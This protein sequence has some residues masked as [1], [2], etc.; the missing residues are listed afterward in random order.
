MNK[1]ES[2]HMGKDTKPHPLCRMRAESVEIPMLA[3][4]PQLMV[5]RELNNDDAHVGD[6]F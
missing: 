6:S 3:M 2:T 4:T 5:D 1:L